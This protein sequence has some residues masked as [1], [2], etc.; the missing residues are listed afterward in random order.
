M[1]AARRAVEAVGAEGQATRS[2]TISTMAGGRGRQGS[3][4]RA[5]V[6]PASRRGRLDVGVAW[7]R[8]RTRTGLRP[9]QHL[10]RLFVVADAR[11]GADRV[12]LLSFDAWTSRFAADP[13]VV[14]TSIVL[15]GAAHT[16]V[17]VLPEGF[18]F[19]TLAEEFW[20]PLVIRPFR[21]PSAENGQTG[22]VSFRQPQRS[23]C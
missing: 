19:P 3:A 17:G 7:P 23:C 13:D 5:R 20:K 21:M 12:V 1:S 16:V 9:I 11:P 22:F 2:S 10:G 4:G 6:G 15:D 8:Q 14:G 18:Y